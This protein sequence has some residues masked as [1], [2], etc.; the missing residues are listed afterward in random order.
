MLLR[1]SLQLGTIVILARQ[2]GAQQYGKVV[3]VIA[4]ASLVIPFVGLGLSHLVLRNA[5]RDPAHEQLY[6]TR[7]LRWWSRTLLPCTVISIAISALLLPAGLPIAATCAVIVAELT[8]A[9]LTELCA[10]HQQALQ[11]MHTVGAVNAGLPAIRLLAIAL[12]I[13]A[14]GAVE[15]SSVLWIYAASSLIYVM[16][17][18][19]A[20]PKLLTLPDTPLPEPMAAKDGLPFSLAGFAMKLQ[21]EFNKPVLAQVGFGLAGTFNV[22]QRAVDIASLPLMALQEALWPRL[23]A[24]Q[25]PTRQLRHTGLALLTLAMALGAG[26]WLAAPL[27]PYLLGESFA[28]AVPTLQLLAWLPLLQVFRGLLNFL[29]IHRARMKLIGWA[30]ALG[31]I[32]S[33]TSVT[34]LVPGHGM[35]G[36]VIACYLSELTMIAYLMVGIMRPIR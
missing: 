26:M 30:Y 27:L 21:A 18:W 25:D 34:L 9:S 3:A 32:M 12:L 15:V 14:N 22:A 6:L 4:V 1:A 16:I 28:D 5:A 24:H 19:I 36:A 10:R 7:A 33:I 2:L 11:K 13:F 20:L 31:A 8:A 29:V 23:Y 17:L 35:N